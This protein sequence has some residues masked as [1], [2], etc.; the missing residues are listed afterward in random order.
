M[1]ISK[2]FHSILVPGLLFA[3]VA[4]AELP[5]GVFTSVATFKRGQEALPSDYVNTIPNQIYDL[6]QKSEQQYLAASNGG[7]ADKTQVDYVSKINT[8]DNA[9]IKDFE[10]GFIRIEVAKCFSGTTAAKVLQVLGSAEFKKKAFA[11]LTSPPQQKDQNTICET[12]K[13]PHL[14]EASYC[15]KTF[16]NDQ[17]PQYLKSFSVNDAFD[18][19]G[20]Y[21]VPVFMRQSLVSARQVGSSVQLYSV[22]YARGP[23]LGS[24]VKIFAKSFIASAQDEVFSKLNEAVK[25]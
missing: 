2:Y 16:L 19:T 21:T 11:T 6:L 4:Q 5:A 10:S 13:T 23:K 9:V 1:K 22:T 14:G 7:C 25:K 18:I 12:S 8:T 17:D 15:Y 3:G 24:L 20:Q